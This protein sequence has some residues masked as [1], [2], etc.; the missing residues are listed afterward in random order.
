MGPSISE[1]SEDQLTFFKYFFISLLWFM[2][3]FPLT[4]LLWNIE[5][6]SIF[7]DNLIETRCTVL[8]VQHRENE[9]LNGHYYGTLRLTYNRGK[10]EQTIWK[11]IYGNIPKFSDYI[12][13]YFYNFEEK[14][15]KDEVQQHFDEY[16]HEGHQFPCFYHK[17]ILKDIFFEPMYQNNGF[18]FILLLAFIC[19]IGFV[20]SLRL[21]YDTIYMQYH[22]KKCC[23]KKTHDF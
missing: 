17:K 22:L 12:G 13:Y 16:F 4:I 1:Y 10:I 21:W 20:V 7:N 14:F 5:T 19:F 15:G 3:L 2:F 6:A 23:K 11:N 18:Y 9:L 8:K